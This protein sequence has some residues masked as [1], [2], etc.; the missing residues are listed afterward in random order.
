MIVESSPVA[1][2]DRECRDAGN[3][4]DARPQQLPASEERRNMKKGPRP[5]KRRRTRGGKQGIDNRATEEAR[6]GVGDCCARPPRR[7]SREAA[8][9]RM[10]ERSPLT[11]EAHGGPSA[12]EPFMLQAPP[13]PAGSRRG[14]SFRRTVRL[15]TRHAGR[16]PLVL[17]ATGDVTDT[18]VLSSCKTRTVARVLRVTRD[19]EDVHTRALWRLLTESE[20]IPNIVEAHR[21]ARVTRQLVPDESGGGSYATWAERM[22]IPTGR[23][24]G[25]GGRRIQY[26]GLKVLHPTLRSSTPAMT[27]VVPELTAVT[28]GVNKVLQARAPGVLSQQKN[29]LSPSATVPPAKDLRAAGVNGDLFSVDG[30]FIRLMGSGDPDV[31]HPCSQKVKGH[32]DNSDTRVVV[33]QLMASTAV[34]KIPG[35]SLTIRQDA[36]P[37]SPGVTVEMTSDEEQVFTIVL[38]CSSEQWHGCLEEVAKGAPGTLAQSLRFIYFATKAKERFT[39]IERSVHRRLCLLNQ[40]GRRPD[41]SDVFS[42]RYPLPPESIEYGSGRGGS[43]YEITRAAAEM[44]QNYVAVRHNSGI[45]AAEAIDWEATGS[46]LR[47]VRLVKCGRIL[48]LTS[49]NKAQRPL[50][51]VACTAQHLKYSYAHIFER[52]AA[53]WYCFRQALENTGR[54]R[55]L[56]VE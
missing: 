23:S 21:R 13:P 26:G 16:N 45:C 7:P 4:D 32:L 50:S 44:C 9:W 51:L 34:G 22:T 18:T 46:L 31:K 11:L 1:Q 17:P 40:Q 48:D 8:T 10:P 6:S 52:N 37:S 27:G 42:D 56:G 24:R 36:S 35:S 30:C 55:W 25:R 2:C 12:L 14:R 33:A 41:L 47:R 3:V 5:S 38:Y 43:S 29:H 28:A 39:T 49:G 19:H 15:R 53:E 54:L 20:A